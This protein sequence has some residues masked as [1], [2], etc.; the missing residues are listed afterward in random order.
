MEARGE[1]PVKPS[2]DSGVGQGMHRSASSRGR[3]RE[4]LADVGFRNGPCYPEGTVALP[5]EGRAA[6]QPYR[7]NGRAPPDLLC[8]VCLPFAGCDASGPRAPGRGVRS[9]HAR[10]SDRDAS[11]MPILTGARRTTGRLN[12]AERLWVYQRTG[13]PCL[14]CGQA[15]RSKKQ[16][17]DARTSFWCPRCQPYGDAA[18]ERL[19][20]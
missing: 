6:A 20:E 1:F 5:G 11:G 14:R 10:G 2:P 8:R 18:G 17:S 12:P 9:P 13:E 15:I 7:D 16:G 4:A 3:A 19:S